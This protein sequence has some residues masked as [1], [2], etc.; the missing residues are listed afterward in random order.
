MDDIEERAWRW[1]AKVGGRT[2][3]ERPTCSH[4]LS[5]LVRIRTIV[6][7]REC[8]NGNTSKTYNYFCKTHDACGSFKVEIKGPE[9]GG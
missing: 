2:G 1:L 4:G 9:G 7:V 5:D 8:E 3:G 6:T